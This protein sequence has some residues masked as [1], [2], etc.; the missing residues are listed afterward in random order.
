M[1]LTFGTS[2]GPFSPSEAWKS[3]LWGS[4]SMFVNI[5]AKRCVI[6]GRKSLRK[7][8]HRQRQE[9]EKSCC[10]ESRLTV[11]NG[12]N[13]GL[14]HWCTRKKKNSHV[15]KMGPAISSNGTNSLK[16]IRLSSQFL[17]TSKAFFPTNHTQLTVILQLTVFGTGTPIFVKD[18][19]YIWRIYTSSTHIN[20]LPIRQPFD[21]SYYNHTPFPAHFFRLQLSGPWKHLGQ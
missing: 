15:C 5:C 13:P 11:S 1:A 20:F 9:N 2:N 16:L 14:A 21:P 10:P 12:W 7:S 17:V 18:L 3:T 6:M 8:Y 4:P 19:L